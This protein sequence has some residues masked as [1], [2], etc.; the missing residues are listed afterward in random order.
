MKRTTAISGGH[1]FA[2]LIGPV[3]FHLFVATS[4]ALFSQT[5]SVS[6]TV[7]IVHEDQLECPTDSIRCADAPNLL[8]DCPFSCPC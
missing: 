5:K 6:G 8:C 4:L 3:T 7:W 2:Q 1:N